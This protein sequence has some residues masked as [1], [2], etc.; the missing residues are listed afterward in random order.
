M[1]LTFCSAAVVDDEAKVSAFNML[2]EKMIFERSETNGDNDKATNEISSDPD[3]K[4]ILINGKARILEGDLMGTNGVVHIVDSVFE[5]RSGLPITSLL[6]SRNLTYF[7]DLMEYGNLDDYFDNLE[8]VTYFVPSNEALEASESGRFW[9]NLLKES[10]Q[11]LKNNEN[12]KSFIS[13]HVVK[14]LLKSTDLTEKMM[15]TLMGGEPLRV[16]LYSTMPSF[17]KVANRATVN[18]ARLIHFDFGK[19]FLLQF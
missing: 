19:K 12:L 6:D 14:P 18:C 1:D 7:K 15:P 13:Y 9:V 17:S 8:N 4:T 2:G 10:P 5:T 16:N 11:K 3:L